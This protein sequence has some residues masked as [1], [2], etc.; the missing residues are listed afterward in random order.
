[1]NSELQFPLGWQ[2]EPDRL[3]IA[4]TSCSAVQQRG[5]ALKPCLDTQRRGRK[6]TQGEVNKVLPRRTRPV[7]PCNRG[8]TTR[9]HREAVRPALQSHREAVQ[10]IHMSVQQ[11]LDVKLPQIAKITEF[12]ETV[13]CLVTSAHDVR[14]GAGFVCTS[15]SSYHS[16]KEQGVI[17]T[18]TDASDRFSRG[19]MSQQLEGMH[20]EDPK[21]QILLHDFAEHTANDRWPGGHDAEGLPKDGYNLYDMSGLCCLA[22]VRLEGLGAAP[23]QWPNVGMRHTT[24][25]QLCWALALD[26]SSV[27]VV[28]RSDSGSFHV[29]STGGKTVEVHC[30]SSV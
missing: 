7:S 11:F 4:S 15:R 14:G 17:Y 18:V 25:L 2:R 22:A 6:R 30:L 19:Y 28:V 13:R 16:L 23:Y 26:G 1:M 29:L 8:R 10:P 20:I 24:A 9:S 27:V 21:H 12:F 5:C 3:W